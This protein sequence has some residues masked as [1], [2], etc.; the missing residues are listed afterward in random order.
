MIN[1][2]YT[3]LFVINTLYSPCHSLMLVDPQARP[4]LPGA[5]GGHTPPILRKMGSSA[6]P[7]QLV[8]ELL[9][10]RIIRYGKITTYIHTVVIKYVQIL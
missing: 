7:R 1:I 5:F 4:K 3:Q 2:K 6:K 8:A 9:E 10:I